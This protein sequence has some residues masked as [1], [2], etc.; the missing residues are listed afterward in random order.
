M[1][2]LVS[3]CRGIYTAVTIIEEMPWEVQ[4]K[5]LLVLVNLSDIQ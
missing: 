5:D 4:T 2:V 1:A 3:A